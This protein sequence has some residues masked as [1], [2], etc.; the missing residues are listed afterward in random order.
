[1]NIKSQGVLVVL[2]MPIKGTRTWC[3]QII[4]TG[5]GIFP[6]KFNVPGVLWCY[7]IRHRQY[8]DPPR[9]CLLAAR[10]TQARY[11]NRQLLLFH[12]EK[13]LQCTPNHKWFGRRQKFSTRRFDIYFLIQCDLNNIFMQKYKFSGIKNKNFLFLTHFRF[14]LKVVNRRIK[15]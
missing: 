4:R 5:S 13:S 1:M 8:V 12:W 6:L 10:P 11:Y 15:L 2:V 7:R 9:P 3:Y 14:I